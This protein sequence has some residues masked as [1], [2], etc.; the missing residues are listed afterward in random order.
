[1]IKRHNVIPEN[2]YN[3]VVR[4]QHMYTPVVVV[5][6]GD[7]AH[8]YVA[9][10]TSTQPNGDIGGTG[11]MGAQIRIVCEKVG[12]ALGSVGAVLD[13][14]VRTI[15][16][17]TD[18]EEYYRCVDERYKVF[19]QPTAHE[20]PARREPACPPRHGGGDRSGSPHRFGSV[21]D[22]LEG[23]RAR[24]GGQRGYALDLDEPVGVDEAGHLHMGA[25]RAM[26][27]RTSP[28]GP[29]SSPCDCPDPH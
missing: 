3:R 21:A 12:Q 10:Q 14:V 20:H 11:D 2:M 24:S 26:F 25:G 5:E 17:T 8:V 28:G 15:T 19:Q 29:R 27:R 1:M 9:G 6:T 4:G 16:Y 7:H 18:I 13:D 22:F 23:R